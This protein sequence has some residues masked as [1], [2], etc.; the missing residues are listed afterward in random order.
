MTRTPHG[1][2]RLAQRGGIA[3]IV[4]LTMVVLI[5]FAGLALDG[6]RLYVNKT[7]TQNAADACALAAS[8]ELTGAP[9]IPL[10]NFPIAENAGRL[11]ATRNSANLQSHAIANGD[12]T[13]EFS[14]A[15]SGASWFGAG[16]ATADAKYVRCTINENNIS[17]WFMQVLGFGNQ[18]VQSMATATLA[19]SQATCTAIPIGM[20][21]N[22]SPP[23]YGFVPGQWYNGGLNNQSSLTGSFNWIDFSPP[24][25]GASELT[26]ALLGSGACTVTP[27][28]SVG[29]TGAQQSLKKAWN[30]RFGIYDPS[31][32]SNGPGSPVP[33]WSGYAYTA[34][35]WPS[36]FNAAANFR[37]TQRPAR[38]PYGASVADGNS[39]TGLD[40]KPAGSTVL[41]S[42]ALND[43]GADR[44]FV[45]APIVDCG[46]LA[47]SQTT[48]VLDWA[49]VLMLHPMTN[50]N[51]ETIWLEYVGLT[52]D[53]GSPCATVGGVG[54]PGS[55]GPLVP[56]L[57]Q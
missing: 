39:I 33:D 9:N 43:R 34:V 31:T 49:C 47:T 23:G 54:G 12:V 50:D 10:A 2:A 53:A 16:A 36:Q 55:T 27:G 46:S 20:C 4:G 11:V 48:S 51:T 44:R 1:A 32:P 22:G 14:T 13:V 7:E 57:V 15:L 5:G 19:P 6:G 17:P 35:N 37:S 41:Q 42:T 28:T 18:T 38:T 21:S 40:V 3:I 56:A 29:Q 45:P 52:T 8:L 26:A 30:T 25:G 24:A